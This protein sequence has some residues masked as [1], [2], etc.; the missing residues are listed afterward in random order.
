MISLKAIAAYYV[1]GIVISGLMAMAVEAAYPKD[2]KWLNKFM[3]SIPV[4]TCLFFV[5][6][7]PIVLTLVSLVYIIVPVLK[8]IVLEF[9]YIIKLLKRI[10]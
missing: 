7:W 10:P 9:I 2:T 3:E 1:A 6:I 5:S 4:L 8:H